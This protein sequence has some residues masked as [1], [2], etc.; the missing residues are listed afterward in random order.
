MALNAKVLREG[1]WAQIPAREL[2]PGD[3]VRIRSGEI[4]PADLKLFEGEYLQVDESAL[5]GESL[6]V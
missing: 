6:P 4:V 3:V 5:T 1:K 2:V